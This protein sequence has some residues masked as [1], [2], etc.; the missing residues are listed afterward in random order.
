MLAM[1]PDTPFGNALGTFMRLFNGQR[2]FDEA[3]L[4]AAFA[5]L[6]ERAAR[7]HPEMPWP[8]PLRDG[9]GQGTC[10]EL[11][12]AALLAL[13]RAPYARR[14]VVPAAAVAAAVRAWHGARVERV[15]SRR[16]TGPGLRVDF[17]QE[18]GARAWGTLL[19]DCAWQVLPAAPRRPRPAARGVAHAQALAGACL[20]GSQ[21]GEDG[22]LTLAFSTGA[23]LAVA[24][25]APVWT[26]DYGLHLEGHHFHRFAGTF[27]EQVPYVLHPDDVVDSDE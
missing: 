11:T 17:T 27:V 20:V 23:Q 5:S 4:H 7:E 3:K 12:V 2:P 25:G 6:S 19:V 13:G 18:A 24:P 9:D 26:T 1:L 14:P 15:E 22:R 21:V 16:R 8:L 10:T